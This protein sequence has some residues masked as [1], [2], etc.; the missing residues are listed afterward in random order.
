LEEIG[1]QR[2]GTEERGVCVLDTRR[3]KWKG[4]F[5]TAEKRKG[6]N[7]SP[8][9]RTTLKQEARRRRK[10]KEVVARWMSK[11]FAYGRERGKRG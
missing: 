6:S 10:A 8:D 1:G 3:G 2:E 5:V 11:I 7:T 4:E 9:S